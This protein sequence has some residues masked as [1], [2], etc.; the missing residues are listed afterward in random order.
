MEVTLEMPSV[1]RL[2]KD[3]ADRITT[4]AGLI[5]DRSNPDH[6]PVWIL[7]FNINPQ[8]VSILYLFDGKR[9][10]NTGALGFILRSS[11]RAEA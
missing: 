8:D 11:D 1:R 6:L 4:V 5:N 9:M 7:R 3:P 10:G 2:K